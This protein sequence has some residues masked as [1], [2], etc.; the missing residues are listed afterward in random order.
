MAVIT[1]T[2]DFGLEDEYVGVMKGVIAAIDPDARVIDICH[3]LKP[4][5]IVQAGLTLDAAFGYFPK[6]TIHLVVVD[7][8]VGTGR[9]VIAFKSADYFFIGPD[10]GVFSPVL[11]R[12]EPFEIVSVTNETY[13]LKSI[14]RTFQGR[15]IFAPV[16][17]YISRGMTLKELG[18]EIGFEKLV[19]LPFSKPR[20]DPTGDLV[21]HVTGVDRFGNLIT[22]IHENC[23]S[24]FCK[25]A[26]NHR[27]VFRVGV[28]KQSFE[29]A[30]A[31]G[32]VDFKMPLAII[33][34]RGY[35]EVAVC[36][37]SAAEYFG[38]H[39]GADV[40]VTIVSA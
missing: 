14:S 2:T 39:I 34:S 3:T 27:L 17:A 5:D 26:V 35:L 9:R 19:R 40:S 37:G 24:D 20:I 29:M 22:D 25:K 32:A 31:Y 30:E 6:G 16:A 4:H 23:L 33:G 36:Q 10:N 28:S 12:G 1:L 15:D 21:G 38:A 7:P 18:P 8:G 13:F 11:E